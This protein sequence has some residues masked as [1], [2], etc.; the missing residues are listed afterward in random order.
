MP[1][2]YAPNHPLIR[3]WLAVARS[4]ISPPP[5]FRAACA[6]LGRLLIYEA[7]YDWLPVLDSQVETPCGVADCTV[8]DGSRPV[9][10][11]PLCTVAH[12][13]HL[14]RLT[15]AFAYSSRLAGACGGLP[16]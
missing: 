7:A 13:W 3:H 2:V 5:I 6:E 11:R 15:L 1:Q 10:A 16:T 12:A 8:V 4:K 14:V 9:K